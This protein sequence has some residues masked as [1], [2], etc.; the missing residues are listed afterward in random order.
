LTCRASLVPASKTCRCQHIATSSIRCTAAGG[1]L[2]SSVSVI[3][4]SGT[5]SSPAKA[6]RRFG[7]C[8]RAIPA[9]SPTTSRRTSISSSTSDRVSGASARAPTSLANQWRIEME[10]DQ[11]RNTDHSGLVPTP[12]SQPGWIGLLAIA[13]GTGV[14][15]GT[16][17][18]WFSLF[19]GLQTYPGIL[20]WNARVLFC[21][22]ALS[23]LAGMAFLFVGGITLRWGLG[24]L[25]VGLL[26]F[27]SW[28][29]LALLRTFG[30]LSAEPMI[31]ARCGPGLFVVTVGALGIFATL[32]FDYPGTGGNH[33]S[34]ASRFV[35][36]ARRRRRLEPRRRASGGALRMRVK[37]DGRD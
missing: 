29:L 25:G 31:F 23:V 5:K 1:S 7:R 22:G 32:F 3:P 4:R 28:L 17:L 33:T 13:G 30:Q 20:G 18:P 35:I 2:R 8:K 15:V 16:L 19:A 36:A 34:R 6:S 24:F 10:G 12:K 21:G 11:L 26:V 14:M 9:G 27:A 37:A